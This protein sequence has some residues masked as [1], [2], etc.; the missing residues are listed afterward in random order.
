MP[1]KRIGE[2]MALPHS[3]LVLT[4]FRLLLP[5]PALRRSEARP[6]DHPGRRLLDQSLPLLPDRPW[7]RRAPALRHP[8]FGEAIAQNW[9]AAGLDHPRA[10][11]LDFVVQ[12]TKRP[13]TIVEAD[14]QVLRD[15][16]YSNRGI[17]DIAAVAAFFA[18]SNR[19]ASATDTRPNDDYYAMAR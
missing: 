18:M 14:R 13:D 19:V 12:L 11:M 9:R 2:A 15:A 6:R 16:G 1:D 4:A 5:S 8:G 10:A 17:F 7:R 3:T